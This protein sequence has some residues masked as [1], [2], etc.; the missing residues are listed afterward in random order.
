MS[1]KSDTNIAALAALFPAAFAAE[2]WQA[3]RPIAGPVHLLG[4]KPCGQ[5]ASFVARPVDNGHKS[6]LDRCRGDAIERH[7]GC[8]S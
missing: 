2:L 8:G 7:S 5:G 3:H 4:S 1:T 6:T